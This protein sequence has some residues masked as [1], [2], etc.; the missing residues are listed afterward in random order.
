MTRDSH[1][2]T[3]THTHIYT[4]AHKSATGINEI[5]EQDASAAVY[6]ALFVAGPC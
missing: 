5:A 6:P 2:H 4:H 1:T 3:H